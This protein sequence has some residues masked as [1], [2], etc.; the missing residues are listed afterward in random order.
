MNRD[1]ND[2]SKG[3]VYTL[4]LSFAVPMI[5]AQLVQVMYNVIDRI[6]IGHL[7]G[8]SADALTG[9]GLTFP[10]VTLIIAFTNLFGMGGAPLCSI[11]RGRKNDKKAELIMGN[12]F[13]MLIVTAIVLMLVGYSV[14][15]PMLYRFGAGD[16]TYP[17]A[18]EYLR[19]YLLCTPFAMIASGMNGFINSQG[20]AGI[21]MMTTLIGAVLNII[22]DPVFIFLLG[23]N[24]KGAA[25]ATVISQFASCIWVMS[26]LLGKKTI[27]HLNRENMRIDFKILKSIVSVGM[28]GFIMSGS[29]GLVQITYNATLKAA[30]G[31]IYVGIMTVLNSLRDVIILPSQG[32]ANASQPVI[33]YNYGAKKYSR[34][35]KAIV[36]VTV[37]SIVYMGLCQLILML[38]PRTFISIFNSETELL[39]LGEPASRIYFLGFVLRALQ[40]AGQAVF[41]GMGLSKHAVFFSLLRKVIIL[42]PLTFVLPNVCGLGVYGVFAA[43]P[44]SNIL[45]GLACYISMIFTV[46]RIFRNE[47]NEKKLPESLD[48]K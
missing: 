8:T 12:T 7:R 11:E 5:F 32:L 30:G 39:R 28:A 45:G 29:T 1:K 33:G 6:Y 9:V 40:N 23:L 44:V 19:I 41:V 46:K 36:F 24:V 34:I 22:L 3:N 13:T 43:E 20:F 25:I 17:Y 2:F 4:V 10:I 48:N 42:I 14:M 38:F 15:K 26:F 35:I 37:S 18:A 47:K 31:D 16:K 21:G 27:L